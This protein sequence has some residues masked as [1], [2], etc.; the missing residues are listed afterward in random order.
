MLI[1]ATTENPSFEV[2]S[3]L[4][5]RTKVF[6]LEPLGKDAIEAL[7]RRALADPR[8]LGDPTI[9][10]EDADLG[11][12][13]ESSQGD[14]RSALTTLEL[15][16][17]SA[18][19][20]PVSHEVVQAALQRGA[21]YYDKGGEE[22]FNMISALHKSLRNSDP[23]AAVYWLARMLESGEDP[24]YVARRMVRFASEDVGLADP[25]ALTIAVAAK[26][27]VHFIGLPE[28]TDALAQAAIYLAT[29]P[30]SN[31][32]TIAYGEAR[33][34]VRAGRTGSVPLSICNAPTPL[35]KDLGYGRGYVYA[36]D[37]P[38]GVADLDCLPEDLKDRRYYRP[39]DRGFEKTVRER[40][41]A[42]A[43]LKGRRA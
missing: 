36:H 42:W 31:A 2:I 21:L 13:A 1:G 34:D 6:V 30:K 15:V 38:E 37:V 39:T 8:G 27:A 7:L 22:H 3:A 40:L 18:T 23:H 17:M 33:Q 24:L 14:A 10:I 11:L 9:A 19:T 43:K 4:L 12:I 28:G 26:D 32:V 5:S 16:A 25:M 29:A 20:G 35:M 41:E